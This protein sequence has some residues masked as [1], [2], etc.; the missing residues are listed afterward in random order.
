MKKHHNPLKK[1]VL[2]SL[3]ALGF[4]AV[5][6][7][8]NQPSIK[9][10]VAAKH[11]LFEPQIVLPTSGRSRQIGSQ[12]YQM[13][14]SGDSLVSY[15]PY[16]GRAYSAPMNGGNALDFTTTKF[17]YSVTDKKKGGWDVLIRPK[18]NSDVREFALTV[19]ENGFA[20][21]R[22]LSNN[23]QPISFNGKVIA[24][25]AKHTSSE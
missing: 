13:K 18:D 23:R 12:G 9:D 6:A 15:L 21:L 11:F 25:P 10:A 7:Q 8:D 19:S 5:L 24:T 20:T 4:S 14:V 2:F 3:L 22:A 16:F 1:L 17:D